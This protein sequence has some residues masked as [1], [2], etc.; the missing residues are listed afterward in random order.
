MSRY[1]LILSSMVARDGVDSLLLALAAFYA[2]ICSRIL[3]HSNY[4]SLGTLTKFGRRTLNG[5]LSWPDHY[6]VILIPHVGQPLA[7]RRWPSRG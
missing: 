7:E 4:H 2:S 3:P 1:S 6:V 5:L